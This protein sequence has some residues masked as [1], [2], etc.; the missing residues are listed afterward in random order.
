MPK[1]WPWESCGW[2]NGSP[3]PGTTGSLIE[4]ACM[5]GVSPL[6]AMCVLARLLGLRASGGL[7]GAWARPYQCRSSARPPHSCPAHLGCQW[8]SVGWSTASPPLRCPAHTQ[9]GS[10]LMC[11]LPRLNA[12]AYTNL[13]DFG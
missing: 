8:F 2:T 9:V 4:V 7:P 13:T 11:F 5:K 6:S 10:R 1:S 12:Q 3:G